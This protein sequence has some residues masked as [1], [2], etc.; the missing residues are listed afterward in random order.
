MRAARLLRSDDRTPQARSKRAARSDDRTP[1]AR[2]PVGGTPG[3][4]APLGQTPDVPVL[5]IQSGLRVAPRVWFDLE[6][7]QTF[8]LPA[9]E[10]VRGGRNVS[11]NEDDSHIIDLPAADPYDP[12]ARILDDMR[13]MALRPQRPPG[14]PTGRRGRPARQYA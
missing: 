10:S 13:G 2:G 1:R 7:V 6:A 4:P 8:Y 11:W 9:A 5:G 14:S 12:V 3:A